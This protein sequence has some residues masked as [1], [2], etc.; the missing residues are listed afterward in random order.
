MIVVLWALRLRKKVLSTVLVESRWKMLLLYSCNEAAI[1]L[2]KWRE[3]PGPHTF[4]YRSIPNDGVDHVVFSYP[5]YS[6]SEEHNLGV[7]MLL[8]VVLFLILIKVSLRCPLCRSIST[9]MEIRRVINTCGEFGK[10]N[11]PFYR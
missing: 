7:L 9:Q 10:T 11:Q 4:V 1:R 6:S 5:S 8:H 2:P 3:V